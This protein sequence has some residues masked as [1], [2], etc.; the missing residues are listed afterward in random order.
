MSMRVV[1]TITLSG[2]M[3]VNIVDG[4]PAPGNRVEEIDVTTLVDTKVKK[5]ARYQIEDTDLEFTAECAG[6][7]LVAGTAGTLTVTVVDNAGAST[8]NS[9]PGFIKSAEP[10]AV[11]IDGERRLLQRI[12]W[13]PTGEAAT[14][15]TGG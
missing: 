2:G 6:T 15:T 10:I 3:T 8:F 14:T 12:V 13:T 1:K 5:T 11:A 7:A 9:V 4:T